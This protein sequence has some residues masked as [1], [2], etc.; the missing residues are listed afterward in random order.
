MKL[1]NMVDESGLTISELVRL[2]GV[3]RSTI[4]AIINNSRSV[5]NSTYGKL[6]KVLNCRIE[7]IKE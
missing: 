5:R 4:Y 3:D 6:A 1:R 2:S 7:D